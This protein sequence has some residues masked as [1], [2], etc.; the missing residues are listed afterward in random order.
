[1]RRIEILIVDDSPGDARLIEE[2]LREHN[3]VANLHMVPD[4][5][6]AMAFLRK[7]GRFADVPRPDLV[8]LD[9]N[10]P[11]KDGRQVLNEIK[12]D[13]DF[14]SIPVLI[15]SMS[16]NE[17]DVAESYAH[18]ANCFITK[19]VELEQFSA[20]MNSIERFWLATVSLPAQRD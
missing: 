7:S 20:V 10:L 2:A 11:R 17:R 15:L 9:L 5:V 14:K 6:D 3:T 1:M 16:S 18:H 4:G 19:P 13:A 8:F 12:T